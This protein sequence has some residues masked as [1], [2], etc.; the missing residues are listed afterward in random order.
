M[1]VQVASDVVLVSENLFDTV[2]NILDL[3]SR[4][5]D[6]LLKECL[7]ELS[8]VLAT[9]GLLSFLIA[10]GYN[11]VIYICPY[12]GLIFWPFT[13]HFAS[14][15]KLVE[16]LTKTSIFFSE[17]LEGWLFFFLNH[18]PEGGCHWDTEPQVIL[19]HDT[20]HIGSNKLVAFHPFGVGHARIDRIT[21]TFSASLKSTIWCSDEQWKLITHKLLL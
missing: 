16:A 8:V 14:C 12:P 1:P 15:L 6:Q 18:H 19:D 9:D 4:L 2:I 10:Y 5:T 20:A 13:T 7:A 17:V 3:L 21:V 11:L